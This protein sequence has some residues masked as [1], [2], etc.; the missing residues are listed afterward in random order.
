MVS[1][2]EPGLTGLAEGSRELAEQQE[3]ARQKSRLACK[4]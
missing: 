1:S 3:E 4:F 2:A